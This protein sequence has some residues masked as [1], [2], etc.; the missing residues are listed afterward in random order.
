MAETTNIKFHGAAGTVTGCCFEISGAGKTILVD[1]GLFQGTRSLERLNYEKLPFDIG[2]VDTI[3]LTHAHLD[4]SGR[5]PCLYAHGCKAPTYC[6]AP[7]AD[8]LKPLLLDSAKLQAASV[9]RRNRRADRAGL[10]PFFPLYTG[11][12]VTK[13]MK[14]IIAVDYC[15]QVDL[16][17]DVSFR[18]W[19]ARHIVGSASAEIN[20]AGQRLLISGDIGSGT[21]IH[22]ADQELGG[23]DH[24]IC[25]ATYG[26]REREETLISERREALANFTEDTL[27]AGGIMKN[28]IVMSSAIE[29]FQIGL[30]AFDRNQ[31]RFALSSRLSRCTNRAKAKHGSAKKGKEKILNR[32]Y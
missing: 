7:T 6:T 24:I 8:I 14:N 23:Y 17:N 3:I 9:E 28:M 25:E 19:D 26:A 4:H 10:P 18:L 32:R 22:C 2:K 15:E 16:G 29:M 27:E 11:P 1:C 30:D 12:D 13:L 21:A 31:I 5:L 20:I